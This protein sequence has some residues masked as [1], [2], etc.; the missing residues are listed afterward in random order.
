MGIN[1]KCPDV[2]GTFFIMIVSDLITYLLL[3][4]STI[5]MG[6]PFLS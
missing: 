5:F 4:V 1:E 6:I 3:F 2:I